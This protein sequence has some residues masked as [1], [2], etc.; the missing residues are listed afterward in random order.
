MVSHNTVAQTHTHTHTGVP[1]VS[2]TVPLKA[3]THT[4]TEMGKTGNK[5]GCFTVSASFHPDT[6]NIT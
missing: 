6:I 1:Q 2:L 3:D 4:H 5:D